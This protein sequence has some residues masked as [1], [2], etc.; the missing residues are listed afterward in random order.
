MNG[1][2]GVG[3]GGSSSKTPLIIG[4]VIVGLLVI[5]GIIVAIV[6]VVKRRNKNPTPTTIPG[7]NTTPTTIPGGANNA[8]TATTTI[9]SNNGTG[10]ANNTTAAT[11]PPPPPVYDRIVTYKGNE[12]GLSIAANLIYA[13]KTGGVW[14]PAV[15]NGSAVKL[16]AVADNILALNAGGDLFATSYVA[17][18]N[19][20]T[21]RLRNVKSIDI[22]TDVVRI[23]VTFTDDS[24]ATYPLIGC[25]SN[26]PLSCTD[27]QWID[28]NA[29]IT[30]ILYNRSV[31][32][33]GYEWALGSTTN[34]IYAR[35]VG[36]EWMPNVL[37]EAVKLY[38]VANNILALNAGGVLYTRNYDPT[39]RSDW[40]PMIYNVQ[41]V[42]IPSS[43]LGITITLLDGTT[44]YAPLFGCTGGIQ[45][46]CTSIDWPRF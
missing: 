3:N 5:A 7:N 29:P 42:A 17:P 23:T 4:G 1:S 11:T 35:P 10:G 18:G 20:W 2:G 28:P 40:S 16:F 12:W 6:F 43:A 13:R 36:G 19:G 38:A 9:P 32:Y 44:K 25:T 8:T 46:T 33:K 15:G 37:G 26:S 24:T 14:Q 45:E 39:D 21:I 30:P 27:I 31:T 22:P 41:S 34:F